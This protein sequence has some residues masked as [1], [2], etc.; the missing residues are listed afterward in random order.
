MHGWIRCVGCLQVA[1]EFY[2]IPDGDA[3][4][5]L[6]VDLHL[7]YVGTSSLNSVTQ[8]TEP[9]SGQVRVRGDVI[10]GAP[11]KHTGITFNN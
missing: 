7:G 6:S 2:A 11:A 1:R 9:S 4:P 3:L 8:L 10:A 5:A